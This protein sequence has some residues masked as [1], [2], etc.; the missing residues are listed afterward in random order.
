MAGE[1]QKKQSF[2]ER[3][4]ERIRDSIGELMTDDELKK[5]IE[6]G[7]NTVFFDP[8]DVKDGY[9]IRQEPALIEKILKDLLKDQVQRE[10]MEYLKDNKALVTQTIEKIIKLGMGAALMDAITWQFQNDLNNFQTNLMN[11]IQT[12]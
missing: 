2:E 4:L 5:I 11:T 6:R 7:M 3:M 12:R 8:T 9:S 10:V 1:I